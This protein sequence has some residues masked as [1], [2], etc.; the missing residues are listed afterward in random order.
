MSE[1]VGGG[2]IVGH[3]TMADGTRV[4]LYKDEA[5]ELMARIAE[6]DEQRVASMPTTRDAL[7][8]TLDAVQRLKELGWREA[9]Y[10]PKSGNPFAVCQVGSTGI[11]TGHYRGDWPDGYVMYAD[12]AS[13]PDGMFWKPLD[14]LT[15]DEDDLRKN[16]ERDVAILIERAA[17]TGGQS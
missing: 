9:I 7:R 10:C 2:P 8:A 1:R 11:W 14:R 12:C 16:C 6:A 3:K 13:R 5:D 4:P 15:P 17:R